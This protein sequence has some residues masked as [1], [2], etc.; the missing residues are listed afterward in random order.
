MNGQQRAFDR[1]MKARAFRKALYAET[2]TPVQARPEKRREFK[3]APSFDHGSAA[4][5]VLRHK[6]ARKGKKRVARQPFK[7]I[8]HDSLDHV[9]PRHKREWLRVSRAS[10]SAL[11][12]A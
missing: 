1:D 10:L 6:A 2:P 3:A 9:H 4:A 5:A 8:P 7:K 11:E 12:A